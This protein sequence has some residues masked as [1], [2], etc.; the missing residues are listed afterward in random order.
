VLVAAHRSSVLAVGQ[1]GLRAGA[2][3]R[4]AFPVTLTPG[5]AA[6]LIASLVAAGLCTSAA[7]RQLPAAL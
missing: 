7:L 2:R 1:P 3:A 6:A 5:E 4:A